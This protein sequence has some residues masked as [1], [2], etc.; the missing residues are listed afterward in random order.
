M[1][2]NDSG[3]ADDTMKDQWTLRRRRVL[4]LA[5]TGVVGAG[6]IGTSTGFA[7]AATNCADGPFARAY[8]GETITLS[9]LASTGTANA[10][11]IENRDLS[12]AHPISETEREAMRDAVRGR[13]SLRL[14]QQAQRPNRDDGKGLQV[15]TEYDGLGSDDT[16][17]LVPSDAQIATGRNKN[18][19]AVNSQVA[20]YDK[21]TGAKE[22]QVD[23]EDIWEPVIPVPEGGFVGGYPF[24][25]DPRAR[26][27]CNAHRFVLAAVQFVQG[28]TNTG[29][30]IGREAVEEGEVDPEN[31][32]RPPRGY[33][34]VAVSASSDPTGK[35]HVYRLPPEDADGPDNLGLVDYPT[36]GLDR[37]AIYL[38]QNFFPNDGSDISVSMVT[39]DKAAMYEGGAVAAHH[40]DDLSN[41]TDDSLD[42]TVQPALQPFTGGSDGTYYLI[43]SVFPRTPGLPDTLTFWELTDPLDDPSL[44]CFTIDV[45]SYA[46]PPDARQPN[47]E[48]LIDTVGLRLMNADYNNET[49]SLWTAHATAIDWNGDGTLVAAIRWYE[50]DTESRTLVQSGIYGDQGRSYYFPTVGSDSDS[51]VI[52]H[53]VS[54]PDTFARMDVAGRTT[55]FVK[56]QL[57]DAVVVKDGKSRYNYGEGTSVMRWGDYNGVSLDPETGHFWTVSQYSPDINFPPAAEVRDP[58]ATRIGEVSFNQ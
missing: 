56:N 29:E 49:G 45:A 46:S 11:G 4:Q 27:D 30:T 47:S 1:S 31:I 23:L 17:G 14:R 43:N 55:D 42:F 3:H 54:G 26:Y 52:V 10:T 28:L 53:N 2:E 35:W 57:E 40:F 25:F 13:Q 20:V 44:S 16:R 12:P 36:L 33:F 22:L 24:V 21:K 50:I 34:V 51:T 15:G 5:G 32:S 39:L 9:E 6:M 7:S 58:Y 37:D 38:T 8:V 19:Q 41:P 18:L 48:A